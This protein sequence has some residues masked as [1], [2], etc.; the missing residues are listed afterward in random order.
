MPSKHEKENA[1]L[2]ISTL[3]SIAESKMKDDHDKQVLEGLRKLIGVVEED[4]F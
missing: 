1:D 3:F 4:L 2:M